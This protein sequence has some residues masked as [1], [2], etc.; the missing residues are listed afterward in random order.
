MKLT[1]ALLLLLLIAPGCTPYRVTHN[2]AY[3]PGARQTFDFY[4]PRVNLEGSPRP[5]L[6]VAHGGGYVGG[7]KAW[8]ESVAE[9]YCLWGYA[10]MA[11]NY[12]L[13]DGSPGGTTWPRQLDDARAALAY[14]QGSDADWMNIRQPVAGLGV[15]AGAH[16]IAALHLQ[17]SLPF[18][19]CVSGPYDFINVSSPQLDESL[20][21]LLGLAPGEHI[22]DADRENLSPV[23]WVVPPADMLLI[24][25]KRD[26]LTVYEHASRMEETIQMTGGQVKLLTIDSSSHGSVWSDATWATRRWLRARQ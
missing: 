25:D 7:D 15:S 21:A 13:A 3:G 10:I 5:V 26:P 8:A 23:S 14:L 22:P 18:A 11:I 9:K 24:H 16:L 17:G 2:L 6:L 12:T 1:A 20:R 4:E 19:V